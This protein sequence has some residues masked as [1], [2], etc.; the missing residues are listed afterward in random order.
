[1]S[2]GTAP[3][4]PAHATTAPRAAPRPG[5]DTRA[6]LAAAGVDVKA[7]LAQGVAVQS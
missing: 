5:A 7:L 6:V 2:P 4:F 3:R 1:M